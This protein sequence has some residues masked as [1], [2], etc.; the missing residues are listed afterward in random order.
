MPTPTAP[1]PFRE[2][3]EE[4]LT[5]VVPCQ[6]QWGFF[7]APTFALGGLVIA[8]LTGNSK[9]YGA[10]I[11][12]LLGFL[13]SQYGREIPFTRPGQVSPQLLAAAVAVANTHRAALAAERAA[14]GFPT[15]TSAQ[16]GQVM[17]RITAADLAASRG[18]GVIR[19]SQ[20]ALAEAQR[21]SLENQAANDL[22]SY[23]RGSYDYSAGG[24]V[25][26]HVQE[27]AA[28]G[29]RETIPQF[30]CFRAPSFQY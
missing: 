18:S 26:Q 24:Y 9:L 27:C 2:T 13:I 7:S 20:A 12:G 3:V 21:Q 30:R 5:K 4:T 17:P 16:T 22:V 1:T 29:W 28:G 6:N 11:G 19:P 25:S 15:P 10:G 8:W 23:C 14:R